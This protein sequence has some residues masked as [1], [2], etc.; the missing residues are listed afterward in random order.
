MDKEKFL[1]E[2]EQFILLAIIKLG[3]Q[4][5]GS[6]MRQLLAEAINRDVSIGALYTTLERMEKKGLV[7]SRMGEATA[8]RGG[9]AKK[10]F[11]VTG[12]GRTALNRSRQALQQMWDGVALR[13]GY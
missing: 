8:K 6:S 10:Y 9:R 1:G 13:H 11:A 12:A 4:A 2:F 7:S 5:Y 3:D